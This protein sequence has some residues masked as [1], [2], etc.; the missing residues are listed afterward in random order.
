MAGAWAE[1]VCAKAAVRKKVAITSRRVQVMANLRKVGD[2]SMASVAQ[3]NTA[4][5][6]A[7]RQ[8][9]RR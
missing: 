3:G 1:V 2:W 9:N 7:K 5:T 4:V 8:M 6:K